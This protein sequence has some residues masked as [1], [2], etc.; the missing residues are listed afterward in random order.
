[1]EFSPW[2]RILYSTTWSQRKN[3]DKI[4]KPT[5]TELGLLQVE[6]YAQLNLWQGATEV[7]AFSKL[8][9]AKDDASGNEKSTSLVPEKNRNYTL[10]CMAKLAREIFIILAS[11]PVAEE[12]YSLAHYILSQ[13]KISRSP[14]SVKDVIF[15]R[16]IA[17]QPK[18]NYRLSSTFVGRYAVLSCK[19]YDCFVEKNGRAGA[20]SR[21]TG[22]GLRE[23]K[24]W[25]PVHFW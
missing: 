22:R 16:S 8:S 7:T 10:R 24:N 11:S 12:A 17:N 20:F 1:M 2:V 25:C 15:V 4:K 14:L 19:K 13:R 6:F 3:S 5:M 23:L 9:C 21:T 18:T